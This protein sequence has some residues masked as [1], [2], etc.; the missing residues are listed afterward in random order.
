[1]EHRVWS[2]SLTVEC[3]QFTHFKLDHQVRILPSYIWLLCSGV[4]KIDKNA[5]NL[6]IV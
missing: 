5:T 2:K 4:D 1:M 6:V 3:A